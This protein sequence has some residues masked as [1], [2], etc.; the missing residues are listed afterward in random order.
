MR[1][2]WPG[3]IESQPTDAVQRVIATLGDLLEGK[4]VDLSGLTLPLEQ[5]PLF[6]RQVYEIARS[7]PAGRTMTYGEVAN[8]LGDVGLARAVGQALGHN[9]WPLIVPCH[10]VV[11]ADG[12]PGGFS[13][14]EGTPTK[15][16][17][18]SIEGVLPGEQRSLFE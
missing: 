9:P 7:I 15:L 18:L 14:G 17:L 1:R 3:G 2:R 6:H 10:R 16:R 8:R 11:A 13:G 12:R 5:V 4:C